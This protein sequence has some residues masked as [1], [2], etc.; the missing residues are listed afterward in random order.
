[1]P[2]LPEQFAGWHDGWLT[3]PPDQIPIT[4]LQDAKNL[5][6]KRP[7]L[8]RVR[9][10]QIKDTTSEI[11]ANERPRSMFRYY[12]PGGNKYFLVHVNT[13]L[14]EYNL[15]T[16]IATSKD[17]TV[18]TTPMTFA[19]FKGKAFYANGV[20]RDTDGTTYQDTTNAPACKFITAKAEKYGGRLFAAGDATS[21]QE[22]FIHISNSLDE[23]TWAAGNIIKL[24]GKDVTRQCLAT[25]P[26]HVVVPCS[27]TVWAV[28]GY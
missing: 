21:G 17:T 18:G 5:M 3:V 14:Y 27:K 25:G 12:K 22:D 10:G 2:L 4:A 19:Q 15:T 16:H 20:I 26:A 11:E 8:V 13:T 9:P 28:V 1:M 24:G 6:I 7:I 23:T